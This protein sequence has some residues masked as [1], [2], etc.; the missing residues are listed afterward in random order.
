[1][2]KR[3]TALMLHKI[4]LGIGNQK[5]RER[6]KALEDEN[7]NATNPAVKDATS[8]KRDAA[9]GGGDCEL[10]EIKLII[11][12]T[13]YGLAYITVRQHKK[14]LTDL[15]VIKLNLLVA[16]SGLIPL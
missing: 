12:F 1:M 2:L 3:T 11:P 5:V 4:I 6:I 14:P 16:Q 15:A 7:N 8:R 10:D 13:W 9:V